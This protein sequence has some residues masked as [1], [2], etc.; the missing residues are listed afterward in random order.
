MYAVIVSGGKQH[1]VEEGE[2]LKLE[3][4]NIE[5]GASV[6]FDRVLLVANGE[7]VKIGAPVVEGAKVSAE[8]VSHGRGK[9]VRIMKFKRRKHHMKQMG[10]RQW[11][12]EVKITGISA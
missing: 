9:K 3:K 5:V 6:D 8:I 4:L 7:D 11:F 2:T 10:H 12:T 1:R